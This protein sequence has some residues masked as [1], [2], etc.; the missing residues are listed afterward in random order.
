MPNMQLNLG[1]LAYWLGE[2]LLQLDC[3]IQLDSIIE[4]PRILVNNF[5][6][7]IQSVN[8]RISVDF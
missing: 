4:T 2:Y 6:D 1:F 7:F 8:N 5:S 3:Q